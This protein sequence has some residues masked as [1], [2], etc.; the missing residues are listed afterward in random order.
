VNF[1]LV[2]FA[3]VDDYPSQNLPSAL[4]CPAVRRAHARLRSD[5]FVAE[6]G[7]RINDGAR[8][9][10]VC[11]MSARRISINEE[12]EQ[13]QLCNHGLP[14]TFWFLSEVSLKQKQACEKFT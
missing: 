6:L 11:L 10:A 9:I 3:S 14:A 13:I 4:F 8:D 7:F 1:H 12:A 2:P 5:S